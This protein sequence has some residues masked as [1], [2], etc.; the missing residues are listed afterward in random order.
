VN[1]SNGCVCCD[2]GSPLN[3]TPRAAAAWQARRP[4][5]SR[6]S[7]SE[8]CSAAHQT[9]I[10]STMPVPAPILQLVEAHS[11]FSGCYA[12]DGDLMCLIDPASSPEL[13]T[14][15]QCQDCL[16]FRVGSITTLLAPGMDRHKLA[17]EVT[18]HLRLVRN[19]TLSFGGYHLQGGGFW[20]SA[21]YWANS[22]VFLLKAD[23]ASQGQ[24]LDRVD[25]L[26]KAFT[27]GVSAPPL[28]GMCDRKNYASRKVY[29]NGAA[30]PPVAS[31]QALF[32]SS[33][34][35]HKPAP[36]YIEVTLAE[37]LPVS[38]TSG[39]G[40]LS[41]PP[42]PA[43]GARSRGARSAASRAPATPRPLGSRCPVCGELVTERALLT[44]VYIGCR[45]G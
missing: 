44:S 23:R 19:Y 32:A 41:G 24:Q 22:G 45:C 26:V 20:L 8:C 42:S 14:Y 18:E 9:A 31:A 15:I 12:P 13:A 3:E 29:L 37:Y 38:R 11:C 2:S 4:G 33:A 27:T 17:R 35:S 21:A 40:V 43:T 25:L 6:P 16:T 28:P 1:G 34:I 30:L 36:G 5:R 7:A 39:A 10:F